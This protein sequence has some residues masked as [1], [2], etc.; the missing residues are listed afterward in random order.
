M[1]STIQFAPLFPVVHRV[2]KPLFPECLWGGNENSPAI[3]LTFDDGPHPDHTPKL[4]DVLG[5][6]GVTASFFWLGACVNRAP[7]IARAIYEQ[8]HWIGLHGYD[9]RSFLRLSKT[10]LKETLQE[11]Q[12]AIT[13]A[14]Q[15]PPEV[16]RDVRP[17]NGLFTPQILKLLNEWDYRPVMWSVVSE[18]WVSPGVSTVIS[19][20]LSQVRNGSIIVLHDG[21][22][23]GADVAEITRQ[24]IPILIEQGY[25]FV[26]VDQLWQQSSPKLLPGL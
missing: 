12:A 25:H 11:T 23:G 21:Y 4:L 9:H 8:E 10:G 18:D 24:L 19:R 22:Y 5:E 1:S 15:L 20:I 6:Y 3:A 16:I 14:C 17:P 2:L 13:N 26:T 7:A